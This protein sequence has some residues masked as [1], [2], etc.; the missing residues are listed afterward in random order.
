[1]GINLVGLPEEQRLAY[2]VS[3]PAVRARRRRE[4]VQATGERISPDEMYHLWLAET[5]DEGLAQQKGT[6]WASALLRS[7]DG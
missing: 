3:M 4:Q 2:L 6:E 1:M 5:G 7:S